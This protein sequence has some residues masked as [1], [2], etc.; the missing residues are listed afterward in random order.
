MDYPDPVIVEP[1]ALPH[2]HTFVILHGRGSSGSKFGSVLL[3]T[4]VKPTTADLSQREGENI[5]N[6]TS[7]FPHA[8]FVFPTAARRRATIYGRALT[9]QWFNNWR[10]DRPATE[11]EDLLIPGL[12]ETTAFV[13]ELLR[14]EIAIVPGG[15]SNVVLGGLSQGC[16][17]SLTSLLLWDGDPLAAW[18]GMC[19]WLPFANHLIEISGLDEKVNSATDELEFDPFERDVDDIVEDDPT[20]QAIYLLTEELGIE[21]KVA[22]G[23]LVE[24]SQKLKQVPLFFG[25]GVEDDRVAVALG[26]TAHGC[27]SRLGFKARWEEYHGLGHWY[28]PEMLGDLA[29]F[30]HSETNW[31]GESEA[32]SMSE[33][34]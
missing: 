8:R 12:Q 24:R 5:Q 13:H 28:S 30:I 33:T 15:A 2:K 32:C 10:L 27:M 34:S 3:D 21:L 16:A 20:A 25:H 9:R 19:G 4:A 22:Q 7:C 23:Q 26:R 1:L 29:D 31:K 14:R 6:L 18:F 11:R 17:A